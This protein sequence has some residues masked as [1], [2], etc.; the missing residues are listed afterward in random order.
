MP[1]SFG[2]EM[3][4][5]QNDLSGPNINVLSPTNPSNSDSDSDSLE[6]MTNKS[7][8]VSMV[9]LLKSGLRSQR[10]EESHT[11][12]RSNS[13]QSN[14]LQVYNMERTGKKSVS[15][16]IIKDSVQLMNYKKFILSRFVGHKQTMEHGHRWRLYLES[17]D[18]N[19]CCWIC[20][21]WNY[22]LFF[23][24]RKFGE[25][26]QI[27]MTSQQLSELNEKSRCM[28]VY[29]PGEMP[30][31]GKKKEAPPLTRRMSQNFDR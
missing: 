18:P 13:I 23:W 14:R 12:L 26:D 24:S 6:S 4:S 2:D 20:E 25:R 5:K 3:E 8:N 28:E 17:A 10:Q 7:K 1:T 31:R 30:L 29:M 16:Q 22:T 19:A 27:K 15:F 21:N 11:M 9:D